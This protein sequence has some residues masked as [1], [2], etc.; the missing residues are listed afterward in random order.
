MTSAMGFRHDGGKRVRRASLKI[1]ST[2]F[3]IA[4]MM[5]RKISA[6]SAV[7]K[8]MTPVVMFASDEKESDPLPPP[9]PADPPA[10]GEDKVGVDNDDND[11]L[12]DDLV[13]LR[14]AAD[15][16]AVPLE[17]D[18]DDDAEAA[19]P[20]PLDDDEEPVPLPPPSRELDFFIALAT[21]V[22]SILPEAMRGNNDLNMCGTA[23][24]ARR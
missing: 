9:P 7:S 23:A 1:A 5:M 10:T 18:D 8:S 22:F 12:F 15:G 19:D 24:M 16:D 17:L 14:D 11:E 6:G 3:E 13:L 20:L 21:D 4:F 2:R